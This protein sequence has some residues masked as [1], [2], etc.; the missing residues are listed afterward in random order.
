[1]IFLFFYSNLCVYQLI[2]NWPG[3]VL[4]DVSRWVQR[5]VENKASRAL[6]RASTWRCFQR[7]VQRPE[8]DKTFQV[9]VRANTWRCF[10]WWVQRSKEDKTSQVEMFT[11]VGST[12][13]E[14][15]NF[16]STG[17]GK[18]SEIFPKVGCSGIVCLFC[19]VKFVRV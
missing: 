14:R 1:M 18:Y 13:R 2:V 17:R 9:L 6:A 3:Q 10:Q 7:W 16:P 4:G 12:T 15:Q 8:E 5:P 19:S 11:K